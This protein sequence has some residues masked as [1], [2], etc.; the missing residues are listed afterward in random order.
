MSSDDEE[1]PKISFGSFS[2][3][4]QVCTKREPGGSRTGPSNS[5]SGSDM[6]ARPTDPRLASNAYRSRPQHTKSRRQAISNGETSGGAAI[7]GREHKKSN[8]GRGPIRHRGM[9][10]PD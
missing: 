7:N 10:M 6:Q 4:S 1:L 2:S 5:T 8:V 3:Q 9:P